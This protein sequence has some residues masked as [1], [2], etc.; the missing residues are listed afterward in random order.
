MQNRAKMK[1][2]V[3]LLGLIGRL[4]FLSLYHNN[5][6]DKPEL[7]SPMTN[8]KR[9][10]II[11]IYFIVSEYSFRL[12]L[13]VNVYKAERSIPHPLILGCKSKVPDHLWTL[14]LLLGDLATSVLLEKLFPKVGGVFYLLN[15]FS[16]LTFVAKSF[17]AI[18]TFLFVAFLR[19]LLGRKFHFA[20]F[21][22]ALSSLLSL[23]PML[24]L[25][26]LFVSSYTFG[27][28][29]N[30]VATFIVSLTLLALTSHIIAKGDF[31]SCT[32]GC[33][34][35]FLDMKANI[36]LW[37]YLMVEMFDHFR[38]FFLATFQLNA[39]LHVIP[40]CLKFLPITFN[41]NYDEDL[42]FTS[43]LVQF[44][45][46]LLKPYPT[47]SDIALFTTIGYGLLP[48][49]TVHSPGMRRAVECI[50]KYGGSFLVL[51]TPAVYSLWMVQ[52]SGNANF[53]F[54]AICAI[55][56]LQMI[57][58]VAAVKLKLEQLLI[59]ANPG[60]DFQKCSQIKSS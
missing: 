10:K 16:G 55:S 31:F 59:R 1:L 4:H 21:I 41:E 30:T 25:P 56:L 47:L 27:K 49:L 15:P 6:V 17:S 46:N 2:Q 51:I 22:L 37:W 24:Q 28:L 58:I 32:L 52:G 48:L 35:F 23:Y 18:E 3:L 34:L 11:Y 13:G 19:S 39:F 7:S 29:R 8:Y 44:L 14:G 43:S 45:V 26:I 20:S 5:L 50:F 33:N 57:G 36:G 42:L 53:Y 9:S 38:S 40:I 54:A 12:G 60:I